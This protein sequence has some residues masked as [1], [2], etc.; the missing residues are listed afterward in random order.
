MN[1]WKRLFR[2]KDVQSNKNVAEADGQDS[3]C[4]NKI[5]NPLGVILL[6]NVCNETVKGWYD[7]STSKGRQPIFGHLQF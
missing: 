1:Q 3:S 7:L 2:F 4:R 5:S 6:E